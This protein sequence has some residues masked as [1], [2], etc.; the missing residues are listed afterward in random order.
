[1]KKNIRYLKCLV[2]N[3]VDLTLYNCDLGVKSI[4]ISI[5]FKSP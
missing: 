1:M 3:L 2:Q 4:Y 5:F